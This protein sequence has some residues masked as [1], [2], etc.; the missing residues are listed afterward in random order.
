MTPPPPGSKGPES[1]ESPPKGTSSELQSAK[2]QETRFNEAVE[3]IRGRADAAA[4]GLLGFAALAFGALGITKA[5]DLTPQYWTPETAWSVAAVVGGFILVS[6]A[7]GGFSAA[8]WK[9]T[10]PVFTS[11][12]LEETQQELGPHEK[13]LVRRAYLNMARLN[14]APSLLAYEA[15]S[16]RL[17]R[18]AARADDT[19]KPQLQLQAD[20]IRAEVR[21][22]QARVAALVVRERASRAVRGRGTVGLAVLFIVGLVVLAGG[23]GF[24]TSARNDAQ[25]ATARACAEA[26]SAITKTDRDTALP[27]RCGAERA[28]T[29]SAPSAEE[30]AIEH[31]RRAL[32]IMLAG[33]YETCLN[34]RAQPNAVCAARLDDLNRVARP[35]N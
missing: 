12:N 11:S 5:T 33:L 34:D 8:L 31:N 15:R 25:I 14:G 18:I 23:S 26:R 19:R 4:K 16:W 17:Q 35:S 20:I 2:D 22:T 6:I 1:G 9:A 21:A 28:R 32:T 13:K 30:A 3:K 7:L 24:L 29:P 27:E 10:K